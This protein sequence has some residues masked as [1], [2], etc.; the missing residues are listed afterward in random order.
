MLF[1]CSFSAASWLKFSVRRKPHFAQKNR[2]NALLLF[3]A[4][5]KFAVKQAD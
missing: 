5:A 1:F 3:P 2:S 4:S